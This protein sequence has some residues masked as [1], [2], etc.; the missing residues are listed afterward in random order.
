MLWYPSWTIHVM[1]PIMD[2][3]CN[4]TKHGP[5]MSWYPENKK[6][7]SLNLEDELKG[8]KG[9]STRAGGG[10]GCFC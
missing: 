1:V 8:E 9:T 4:G 2:N 5:F 7:N 6:I 3:S 10:G